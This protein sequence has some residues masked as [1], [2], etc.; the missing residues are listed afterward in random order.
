[1]KRKIRQLYQNKI[2][3]IV[4]TSIDGLNVPIP[5][6]NKICGINIEMSFSKSRK[7]NL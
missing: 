6:K 3:K 7:N 1:M 2:L 4:N 5:W